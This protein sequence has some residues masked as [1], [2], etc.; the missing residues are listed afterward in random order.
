MDFKA[1][2]S[3]EEK[4]ILRKPW[5]HWRER[6]GEGKEGNRE[7][8]KGKGR[9]KETVKAYRTSYGSNLVFQQPSI[10]AVYEQ[11]LLVERTLI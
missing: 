2:T 8:R 10:N 5:H 6:A 1:R 4:K 7:K 11:L 3:E 9:V